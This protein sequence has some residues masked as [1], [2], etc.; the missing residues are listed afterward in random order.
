MDPEL[1]LPR[2]H[3]R[4]SCCL[5]QLRVHR[6]VL[7]GGRQLRHFSTLHDVFVAV[8]QRDMDVRRDK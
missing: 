5:R 7:V 4:G 1:V 3:R 2:L 8:R 6:S